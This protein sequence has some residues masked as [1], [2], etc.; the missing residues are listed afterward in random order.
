MF[1][2]GH[3]RIPSCSFPAFIFSNIKLVEQSKVFSRCKILVFNSLRYS[4]SRYTELILC[5]FSDVSGFEVSKKMLLARAFY[6]VF[7]RQSCNYHHFEGFSC[8][9]NRFSFIE[10]PIYFTVF[11]FAAEC[12]QKGILVV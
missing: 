6:C 9:I 12:T 8:E 11:I 2:S 3:L 7:V 1:P 10:L 4:I 5:Q